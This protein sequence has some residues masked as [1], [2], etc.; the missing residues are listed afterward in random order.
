MFL[1][2]IVGSVTLLHYPFPT[3]QKIYSNDSIL[4]FQHVMRI[5]VANAYPI[6][7]LNWMQAAT[8]FNLA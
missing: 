7:L 4:L 2:T 1:Q 6:C 5:N 3:Y 8:M